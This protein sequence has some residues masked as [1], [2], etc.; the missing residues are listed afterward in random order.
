MRPTQLFQRHPAAALE[1]KTPGLCRSSEEDRSRQD[2]PNLKA[3][4]KQ[5]Q[6]PATPV[7]S[8]AKCRSAD[9]QPLFADETRQARGV[10]DC[11][12]SAKQPEK[13]AASGRESLVIYKNKILQFLTQVSPRAAQL[14]VRWQ[15]STKTML[16]CPAP[17]W[18]NPSF[19]RSANGRPPGPGWWYAVHFHQPGPGVLPLS[20]A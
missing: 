17:A 16:R 4:Q 19:K 7:S 3:R 5:I 10:A 1:C 12:T 20:P 9:Q 11:A 13:D 2:M 18:P 14:W 8:R 15:G 6:T